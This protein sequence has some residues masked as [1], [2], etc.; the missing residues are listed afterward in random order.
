MTIYALSDLHLSFRR[1]V[2]LD[3]PIHPQQDIAKP[4]DIFGWDRHYEYI[5]DK[6]RER[7][8]PDDT[9]LIPGD[10]SWG[11]RLEEAVHDFRWIAQL[12]GRKILSPGN[13]CY[14]AASKKKVRHVLPKGMEWI[15]ADST[16][17]EGYAIVATRGWNI[18]GDY[19][20]EEEKDRKIYERQVGRLHLALEDAKKKY[21]HLPIIAML[22]YPPLIKQVPDS[23]F[24]QLL[25]QYNVQLCLYGHLHGRSAQIAV[26]GVVDG[27][28]LRL[29]A[30]DYLNFTPL[31]CSTLLSSQTSVT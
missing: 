16:E 3:E 23:G 24:W 13:H 10:I 12:P 7:V 22:H 18:P 31:N 6:W 27:I 29:V 8:N 19:H 5:R 20:F 25:Q 11:M 28:Q 30:C 1:D 26:E 15:D 21:P 14:Y 17:V 2:Q 4:M 9:I